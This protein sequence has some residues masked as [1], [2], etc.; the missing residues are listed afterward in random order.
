[1]ICYSINRLLD[2]VQRY[3]TKEAA[4]AATEDDSDDDDDMSSISSFDEDEAPGMEL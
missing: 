1:M 3:A 4:D 2:Y